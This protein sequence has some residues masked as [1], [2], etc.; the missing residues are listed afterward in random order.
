VSV[1][2]EGGCK[3]VLW[4]PEGRFGQG[5]RR[6]AGELRLMLISPNGKSDAE[7][8]ESGDLPIKARRGR[9]S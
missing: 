1:Y 4:I 7:V 2:A 9:G 8:A 3:G 6:F 5:W